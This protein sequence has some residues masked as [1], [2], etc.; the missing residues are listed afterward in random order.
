MLAKKF[1]NIFVAKYIPLLNRIEGVSVEEKELGDDSAE[2]DSYPQIRGFSFRITTPLVFPHDI[3]YVVFRETYWGG[4]RPPRTT[5]S[6]TE[7]GEWEI[8]PQDD[9]EKLSS[10]D[11]KRF[12][13]RLNRM[14]ARILMRLAAERI[15][16][17]YYI[18]PKTGIVLRTSGG[19]TILS[20]LIKF[21]LQKL[22]IR[23]KLGDDEE[24]EVTGDI[25]SEGDP[26]DAIVKIVA[27]LTF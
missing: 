19:R 25:P 6:V 14:V 7:A 12:Y 21:T 4:D 22:H 5:V 9:A 23:Y 13:G 20:L 26:V 16:H 3:Y 24:R 10:E 11:W 15:P 18:S 17:A 2:S 27:L 8:V 1:R